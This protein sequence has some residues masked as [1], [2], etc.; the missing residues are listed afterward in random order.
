[1]DD[2]AGNLLGFWKNGISGLVREIAGADDGY[3]GLMQLENSVCALGKILFPF[4]LSCMPRVNRN[5]R[6]KNLIIIDECSDTNAHS[7]NVETLSYTK[8]TCVHRFMYL[9]DIY[10]HV[11]VCVCVS[12]DTSVCCEIRRQNS[13]PAEHY[14]IFSWGYSQTTRMS[15]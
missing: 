15:Q 13:I 6:A 14:G 11:C 4:F 5:V 8:Y 2:P 3:S 10:F 9:Y 12:Q 1:M 7:C